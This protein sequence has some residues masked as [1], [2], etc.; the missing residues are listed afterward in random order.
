M[1]APSSTTP[2]PA[3]IQPLH[4]PNQAAQ[5]QVPQAP[6]GNAT[7]SMYNGVSGAKALLAKKM[8]KANNPST[9]SPTDNMMTPCTAKI[10]QTKKKHFAKGPVKALSFGAPVEEDEDE[11][12]PSPVEQKDQ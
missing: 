4:N 12:S 2:S 10:A 9:V 5:V 8:A 1:S 11:K 7:N 6:L 3:H